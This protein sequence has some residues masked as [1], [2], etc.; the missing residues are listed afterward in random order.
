MLNDRRE[1]LRCVQ[2]DEM[3]ARLFEFDPPIVD[4]EKLVGQYG[5]QEKLSWH[6]ARARQAY[7]QAALDPAEYAGMVRANF[8]LLPTV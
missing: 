5:T 6:I 4:L 3:L 1:R 2:C 8:L 7:R